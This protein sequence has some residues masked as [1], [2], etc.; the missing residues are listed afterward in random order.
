LAIILVNPFTDKR[1]DEFILHHP[2]G[3]IFH[4][5][6]W[7]RVLQERYNSDPSYY[8]IENRQ[9][10]I[11][12][13][14]P[15]FLISSPISG[16]RL[17]CLPSSEYCFPLFHNPVDAEKLIIQAQEDVRSKHIS[18]LEIRGIKGELKPD[19]LSLKKHP[20]YLNHVTT[21][22]GNPLDL[23]A[24]LSRDTRYHLN[25]GE[26]SPITIRIAESKNDL[27]EFHQLT[28]NM[29]RRINL[30]PLPYRFFQSIYRYLIASGY[31]YILLAEVDRK[32]V[33]GGMFFGYKD[34]IINKF[35]ASDAR[36]I[37]LRT[38]YL[39]MWKAIERAYNMSYRYFDF[40][41]TNPENTGLIKF[42]SH[43]DSLETRLP[44]YYYPSIRG[45]NSL[46]ETSLI[47]RA[48]TTINKMLPD[49]ALKL[50]AE[51]LYKRMG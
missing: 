49:F 36:Y 3:T 7:A 27:K 38:N 33:S 11:T 1:W 2:E 41:I 24:R 23:R 15:F 14:A 16:R 25:R 44:Y 46:P 30:L 28:S 35:N 51:L 34:T 5:S 29:R 20:Y 18:Y 37:Q 6:A 50:A 22:S 10:E 17:V 45:L 4:T 32:I 31:G 8:A 43:W 13:V 21:L 48:H 12:A 40:G 42:K 26:R 9:G 19:K 47:Y 39:I